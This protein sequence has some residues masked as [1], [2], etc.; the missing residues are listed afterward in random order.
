MFIADPALNATPVINGYDSNWEPL[1]STKNFYMSIRNIR[2]DTS[3]ITAEKAAVAID[4]SVSQACSMNN[5]HITMPSPSNHTGI[6][7]KNG[8]SG[9]ILADSVG[10]LICRYPRPSTDHRL[11]FYGRCCRGSAEQPAVQLQKSEFRWMHDWHQDTVCL[12]R[13]VSESDIQQL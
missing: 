4:W 2:I 11:E 13:H 9:T 1:S 5:V 6:T 7:M 3:E 10:D 12:C 8:G